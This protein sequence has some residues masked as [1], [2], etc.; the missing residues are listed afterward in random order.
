MENLPNSEILFAVETPLNFSVRTTV[1]YWDFI[2]T[3]KHPIMKGKEVDVRKT[4]VDPD[5]IRRSKTDENVF[6][7]YRGDGE[8]R[9]V[10]AVTRKLEEDGFLITAYRTSAIKEGDLLWQK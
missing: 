10:C 7:F 4:L 3:I 2:T 9:W 1:D 6:L 5:E 8:R